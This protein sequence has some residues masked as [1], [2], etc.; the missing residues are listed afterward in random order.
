M[1]YSGVTVELVSVPLETLEAGTTAART[2]D[3]WD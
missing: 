3:C 2:A 1:D